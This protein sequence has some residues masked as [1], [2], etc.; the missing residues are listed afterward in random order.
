MNDPGLIRCKLPNN[1]EIF[2]ITEAEAAALYR[3]I[4]VQRCWLDGGIQLRE[5]GVVV[6]AG[7]NIGISALFFHRQFP[8]LRF[9]CYEPAPQPFAALSRNVEEHGLDAICRQV[10]LGAR[11]HLAIMT[12]YPQVTAM[13]G[14]YADPGR[15]AGI[16][17]IY[18]Q[19][20]GFDK[21]DIDEIVPPEY[22][23]APIA[24]EVRTLSAEIRDAGVD[25]IDLLKIDVEKSELDLLAGIDQP[26][27]DLIRQVAV[28]VHD[29]DGGLARV[30]ADLECQGFAVQSKQ[31]PLLLGTELYDVT[32]IR[33]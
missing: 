1:L 2:C 27:W 15:E 23:T 28:E 7:A 20:C 11:P 32:G 13:S 30:C 6:D 8:K 14:L 29:I 19:N 26:T 22:V 10:A 17:R 33:R 21:G 5:G 9:L 24:T 3:E 25:H 18:L 31:S 4:F 12:Y 16:T